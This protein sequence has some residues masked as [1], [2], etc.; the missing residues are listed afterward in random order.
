[1]LVYMESRRLDCG[2]F[3]PTA[4][5]ASEKGPLARG[6]GVR[7]GEEGLTLLGQGEVQHDRASGRASASPLTPR[8]VPTGA[9][10]VRCGKVGGLCSCG[11]GPF[12]Y[13]RAA[14]R[15]LGQRSLGSRAPSVGSMLLQAHRPNLPSDPL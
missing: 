11:S 5:K 2:F 13:R 14:R 3:I 12:L 6:G 15:H 7:G 9:L 10:D 4:C 8:T 1:M